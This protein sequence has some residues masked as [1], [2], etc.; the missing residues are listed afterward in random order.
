MN[1]KTRRGGVVREFQDFSGGLNTR[2]ASILENPKQVA[3]C[4]NVNFTSEGKVESR[5]GYKRIH[6]TGMALKPVRGL[7]ERIDTDGNRSLYAICGD[8]LYIFNASNSTWNEIY[9]Y[10]APATYYHWLVGNLLNGDFSSHTG[11]APAN[12]T[13]VHT[14]VHTARTITSDAYTGTHAV[15]IASTATVEN[16]HS[17]AYTRG[18]PPVDDDTTW[19]YWDATRTWS[20][21]EETDGFSAYG[22]PFVRSHTKVN[23]KVGMDFTPNFDG[24][25]SMLVSVSAT[26][27]YRLG[28]NCIYD[29]SPADL[30]IQW[31][32]YN[33]TSPLDSWIQHIE[34]WS[35]SPTTWVFKYVDIDL[36]SYP[37]ADNIAVS[38]GPYS[39]SIVSAG[40][41]AA[42]YGATLRSRPRFSD[43]ETSDIF[44]ITPNE[45]TKVTLAVKRVS[46]D[47]VYS[48]VKAYVKALWYTGADVYISS[49]TLAE[50]SYTSTYQVVTCNINSSSIPATAGKLK[51]EYGVTGFIDL[52]DSTA[53][54]HGFIFSNFE[55]Q[56]YEPYGGEIKEALVLDESKIPCFAN[57]I[58]HTYIVGYKD[59]IK[60]SG[61]TGVEIEMPPFPPSA[62]YLVLNKD[63]MWYTGDPDYPY[64]VYFTDYTSGGNYDP[65]FIDTYNFYEVGNDLGKPVT[66]LAPVGGGIAVFNEE[67]T[68]MITGEPPNTYQ[69]RVSAEVGCAAHRTIAVAG[70]TAFFLASK[71]QGVYMFN[72]SKFTKISD[73]IADNIA[74]IVHEKYAHAVVFDNKYM[75]FCDDADSEYPYNDTVYVYDLRLSN[76]TKYKGIYADAAIVRRFADHDQLLIGT[77]KDE[78]LV[79]EM[80]VG[81]DDDGEAI[82]SYM[83]TGDMTLRGM[84]VEMR[85]RKVT[86]YTD[87]GEDSEEIDI[88]YASDRE[89]DDTTIGMPIDYIDPVPNISSRWGVAEW[90]P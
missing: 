43:S 12:W 48:D 46:S 90:S 40:K 29:Y 77:S 26:E 64:A 83:T 15:Q 30:Y 53:A 55:I 72:G 54:G 47:A 27:K 3:D 84:G 82:D 36:S 18:T 21:D 59:N 1:P 75:L 5:R 17:L 41:Y 60:L 57:Y 8:R 52:Y 16:M 81:W 10:R 22:I 37:T 62:K 7:W 4:Q 33:G 28:I 45:D 14:G 74:R 2:V 78:G 13:G 86:S 39:N 88:S 50:D 51:I 56:Q 69:N 79:Y 34:P 25:H 19:T 9:K 80:F 87:S 67:A 32:P 65:D 11:D 61:A 71:E 73:A 24:T 76:W 89:Y 58:G 68:F 35:F 85:I 20:P 70:D 38:F 6:A 66:G 63:R 31:S 44:V 23:T 49:T 42:M